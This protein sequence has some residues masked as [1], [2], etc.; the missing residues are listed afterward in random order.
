MVDQSTVRRGIVQVSGAF[1][2]EALGLPPDAR[3]VA[4]DWSPGC[5]YGRVVVESPA[6]PPLVPATPSCGMSLPDVSLIFT[7]RAV[8]PSRLT[9]PV[10]IISCRWAHDPSVTWTVPIA[11]LRHET[12]V[13][14]NAQDGD[15]SC[16][17]GG[18]TTAETC[19]VTGDTI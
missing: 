2:A 18:V 10:C 3:I 7:A 1:L 4:V 9:D 8:H 13:A 15:L 5:L 14:L 12:A 16:R 19:R 6:L 11:R 17:A